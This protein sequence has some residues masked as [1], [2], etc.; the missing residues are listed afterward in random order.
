[1]LE[2]KITGDYLKNHVLKDEYMQNFRKIYFNK[3]L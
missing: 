3:D 1:M 2:D